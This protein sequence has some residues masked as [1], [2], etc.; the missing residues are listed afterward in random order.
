MSAGLA[1]ALAR[2]PLPAPTPDQWKL[3]SF[4]MSRL[5]ADEE[6]ILELTEALWQTATHG[7][8][9]I[10]LLT[11]SGL[12]VVLVPARRGFLG[13]TT[14]PPAC[15]AIGFEAVQDLIESDDDGPSIF[16]FGK[17]EKDHFALRFDTTAER[18]RMMRLIFWAHRQTFSHWGL[19]LDPANYIDDFDRFHGELVAAG[20]D[21]RTAVHEHVGSTYG[22]VD[23][24]NALGF[25]MD[26]R[27]SELDDAAGGQPSSRVARVAHPEP[28][29]SVHPMA[30]RLFVRLGR[31][32]Y[33]QGLLAPPY[34]ERTFKT[35]EPITHS[36]A[37]PARLVAL[38]RLAAFARELGDPR[39]AEWAEA[40]KAGLGDVPPSAI[41]AAVREQWVDIAP[42]PSPDDD[43]SIPIWEDPE[44]RTIALRG[45]DGVAFAWETLAEPDR[46]RVLEF[47]VAFDRD[48]SDPGASSGDLIAAALA[49]IRAYEALPPVAPPGWRKLVLHEVSEAAHVLWERFSSA[50]ETAMLARWVNVSIERAGW[51][52]DG[53]SSALGQHH[54]Y[55]MN[56][57]GRTGIG[58]FG[59][60][61][62]TGS[63]M[64]PNGDEARRAAA[65][66]HF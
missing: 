6:A 52:P 49:G 12:G 61:P 26:W 33:E 8:R 58:L 1:N 18:S 64:V 63:F 27:L 34:D 46:Q 4:G 66:G 41:P 55:T 30:R 5:R 38:M 65:I 11:R 51:G 2:S 13:R 14:T 10:V 48:W 62:Q 60:D 54:S 3:I 39:A 56:L 57:A 32:L 24:T 19:Q 29:A 25:A 20:L 16:F 44:V 45:E 59:R 36:D 40:A 17:D 23:I 53:N 43:R 47:L 50:H 15:V 22:E 42:V 21:T 28:W 35:G 9:G 31:E 7:G 37:G